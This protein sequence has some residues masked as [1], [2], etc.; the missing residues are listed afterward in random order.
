[1]PFPRKKKA[2]MLLHS[3]SVQLLMHSTSRKTSKPPQKHPLPTRSPAHPCTTTPYRNCQSCALCH[4]P[5]P[6]DRVIPCEHGPKQ[7]IHAEQGSNSDEGLREQDLW[8]K[9]TPHIPTSRSPQ[10]GKAASSGA[11][12]A[13]TTPAWSQWNRVV[14][15]TCRP[16]ASSEGMLMRYAT[17][18]LLNL[19]WKVRKRAVNYVCRPWPQDLEGGYSS[20]EHMSF[21]W[22]WCL[23]GPLTL[24]ACTAIWPFTPPR[25]YK[26]KL[27]RAHM[28][29]ED[30]FAGVAA[31]RGRCALWGRHGKCGLAE[32]IHRVCGA[33]IVQV[34]EPQCRRR[35]LRLRVQQAAHAHAQSSIFQCLST[36]F[37]ALAL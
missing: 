37:R 35:R 11:I 4:P 15:C 16:D 8:L 9:P 5:A 18:L 13:A 28:V 12:S 25:P 20:K 34:R 6:E 19:H 29:P 30:V 26:R 27:E 1:M 31:D 10:G 32:H 7:Q 14:K 36:H 23:A 24:D 3:Q 21:A 22:H 17:H 33:R 2:R